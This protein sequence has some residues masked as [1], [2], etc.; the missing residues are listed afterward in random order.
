MTTAQN[1]SLMQRYLDR[2]IA[3]DPAGFL[4]L[5]AQDF[6]AHIPAGSVNRDGFIQHNQVFNEAFSEKQIIV[7]DLVAEED[8]V[9]ARVIWRGIQ[10]GEFMGLQASHKPVVVSAVL[11]ERI[12]DGLFVEHWSLF[13]R[14]GMLQQL[15][16]IPGGQP[17]R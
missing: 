9:V 13:D 6:V 15:G 7:E 8:K 16:V 3:S 1:K 17:A 5:M 4:E 12:R 11:T 14:M 2:S 10:T